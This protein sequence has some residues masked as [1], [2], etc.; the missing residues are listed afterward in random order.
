[1]SG[2]EVNI[3]GPLCEL[4]N[5]I[6]SRLT[7]PAFCFLRNNNHY[8]KVN[9]GDKGRKPDII[10]VRKLPVGNTKLRWGD[11]SSVLE[12]KK[13]D[14]NVTGNTGMLC[15]VHFRLKLMCYQLAQTRQG[16]LN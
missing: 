3:Y 16:R 2:N 4:A 6:L 7:Q 13:G 12:V 11:V 15:F 8:L 5:T 14:T 9:D 1:M 10:I